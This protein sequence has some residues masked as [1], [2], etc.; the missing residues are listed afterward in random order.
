MDRVHRIGQTRPV[1]VFRLITHGTVEE[2][3][4]QRARDK[5]YLMQ[6]TMVG[7]GKDTGQAA[8]E[9]QHV[10]PASKVNFILRYTVNRL[11]MKNCSI[12][13]SRPWWARARTRDR[14][15]GGNST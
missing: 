14:R 8:G 13:S 5:L 12:K 4:V 7:A 9:E 1:R 15:L 10:A 2:R 11:Y 6:Q 3:I